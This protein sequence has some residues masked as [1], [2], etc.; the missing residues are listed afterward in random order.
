[1]IPP[2]SY[3]HWKGSTY[4]VLGTALHTEDEVRLVIYRDEAGEL[5]ARPFDNFLQDIETPTG[6]VP[7][8]R[9]LADLPG[10]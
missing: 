10:S 7:R 5:F 1:M 2:G 6:I 3:R 9:R 8:F 4:E